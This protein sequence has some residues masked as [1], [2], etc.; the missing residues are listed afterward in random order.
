MNG[1]KAGRHN[2]IDLER[3]VLALIC[4]SDETRL[5]ECAKQ[6]LGRY[7]WRDAAYGAIFDIAMSFPSPSRQAF[8]DQLPARL[9]RRG[10]PDFD[11][12]ALYGE[13]AVSF[14]EAERRMQELAQTE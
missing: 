3:R 12:Q 10:F 8:R 4:Q 14:A 1:M 7:R 11:L 9:T 5:R 13:P 6:L 2:Q